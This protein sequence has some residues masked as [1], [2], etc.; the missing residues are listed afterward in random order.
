MNIK[1]N[2]I[3]LF[4][5]QGVSYII[6]LLQF[7]YLTRVLGTENFGLYVFSYSIILF[8]LT[9]TNYGF[10]I[11]LPKEIAE[12][13]KEKSIANKYF[14]QSTIIRVIL[15]IPSFFILLAIYYST[16]KY[17]GQEYFLFLIALSVIF[18]AFSIFWFYQG[19][20]I[21]YL[22]SRIVVSVRLISILFIFTF[23]R[24]SND[25]DVAL[26]I[27]ALSNMSILIIS[28]YF[29]YKKYK[30]TLCPVNINDIFSLGKMSFEYFISRVGLSMYTAMGGLIIGVFSDSLTQVAL[31]GAAQQLYSAGVYSVSALSIP[32]V[33]YMARTKNYTTFFN[34]TKLA[35]FITLCGACAGWFF[36]EDILQ[37]IYGADF[38][39]AKPILD[40]FMIT[41][42]FTVIGIHFGFPALIPL[43]KVRYANLSVIYAGL[44]QL[45]MIVF[46]IIIFDE[47]I[48]AI[49][50][51]CTYLICDLISMSYRLIVFIKYWK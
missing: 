35:I 2:I 33:P 28:F 11:C 36:G 34:V 32:L 25:L 46:I 22:Y 16:K 37:L 9:I 20:E 30:L 3:N 17:V 12:R 24:H 51:T 50:V 19:K 29:A 39:E 27:L 44:T 47:P 13:S 49:I 48:T 6:P 7:P 42:I 21:I 18:N 26:L 1:R 43:G 38:I 40:I 5:S 45:I 15:L 41:I 31:Y 8:L 23:V 10:E 14:T 4:A